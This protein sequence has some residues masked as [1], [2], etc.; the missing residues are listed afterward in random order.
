M[1]VLFFPL[2]EYPSD[3]NSSVIIGKDFS[4]IDDN[5]MIHFEQTGEQTE[6]FDPR[7]LE[8]A[9]SCQLYIDDFP[10]FAFHHV[11]WG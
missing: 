4:S 1:A 9:V 5:L 10:I 3:F 6:T 8:N 2:N 7:E 11:G